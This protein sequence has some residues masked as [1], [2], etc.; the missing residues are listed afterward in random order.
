MQC[1]VYQ[2]ITCVWRTDAVWRVPRHYVCGEL[3]QI[4]VY[5]DITC[6]WRTDA[7]WRVPR[8]YVCVKN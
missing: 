2:D 8:H 4:G 5:Q 6:V 1:G 7:V 3:M